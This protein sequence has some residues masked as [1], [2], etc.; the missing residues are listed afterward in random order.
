M[1]YFGL[2]EYPRVFYIQELFIKSQ[3]HSKHS[4]KLRQSKN[5]FSIVMDNWMTEKEGTSEKLQE[6]L[7]EGKCALF[8]GE[9]VNNGH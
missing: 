8:G 9:K 4:G 1:S 2:L 5:Y 6:S 3:G 7:S